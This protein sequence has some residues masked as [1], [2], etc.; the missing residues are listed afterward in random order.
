MYW[1]YYGVFGIGQFDSIAYNKKATY[2]ITIYKKNYRLTNQYSLI[3]GSNPAI[4]KYLSD[5]IFGIKGSELS[6]NL[7][8]IDNQLPLSLFFAEEEDTFKVEFKI[9][10]ENNT[11]IPPAITDQIL[12][13]GY[14]VPEDSAEILSDIGHEIK[15]SFTDNLGTLKNIRF[16]EAAKFSPTSA[17]NLR[18]I[19]AR[20]NVTEESGA[21]GNRVILFSNIS[22]GSPSVGDFVVLNDSPIGDVAYTIIKN[23]IV[24]GNRILEVREPVLSFPSGAVDGIKLAYVTGSNV[25]TR[26]KLADVLRICL[27]ATNLNLSVYY[28]GS[29]QAKKESTAY[30]DWLNNVY[31]DGRTFMSD[32]NTFMSCYDVLQKLCERF[33]MSVFMANNR[34][35]LVRWHESRYYNNLITG[36]VYNS[37]IVQQSTQAQTSVLTYPAGRIEAGM[38]QSLERPYNFFE[39]KLDYKTTTNLIYNSDL[40]LLGPKRTEYNSGGYLVKEYEQIGFSLLAGVTAYDI[41]IRVLYQNDEEKDRFVVVKQLSG[42]GA[43]NGLVGSAQGIELNNGDRIKISFEV[44]HDDDLNVGAINAIAMRYL[45]GTGASDYYYITNNIISGTELIAIQPSSSSD[46]VYNK[47]I[48][49]DEWNSYEIETERILVD[50]L[51]TFYLGMNSNGA[52]RERYYKNIRV[53][54][55]PQ[56]ANQANINGHL[57]KGFV[58]KVT[59]NNERKDI[60]LDDSQRNSVYGTLFFNA[61]QNLIQVRTKD[62]T[63]P[64]LLGSLKLGEFTTRQMMDWKYCQRVKLDGRLLGLVDTETVFVTFFSHASLFNVIK[65]PI[66]NNLYFIFGKAKFN[67]REDY[68]DVTLYEMWKDGEARSTPYG[69]GLLQYLFKFLYK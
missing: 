26:I 1:D 64:T 16:D 57:N 69:N 51:F 33:Q 48:T 8:N 40:Q 62:W 43:D 45:Y 9:T 47:V 3:C 17:A 55:I 54:L 41:F 15:L 7:L 58:N 56:T 31:V 49:K 59:K 29:L 13:T 2:T 67:F 50:S 20:V 66:K 6:L 25:Y 60:Y 61:F 24:S 21:N 35:Y 39:E 65:I 44:S 37:Y 52:N 4:L 42:F 27:H 22:S 53:E 28:A 10:Y 68:I 23:T 5:D 36:I 32:A 18:Q 30:T 38:S 11:S 34:W 14:M 12:F 46:P 63:M 19:S